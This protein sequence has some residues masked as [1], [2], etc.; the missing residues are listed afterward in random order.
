MSIV[1]HRDTFEYHAGEDILGKFRAEPNGPWVHDPD[2]TAVL[3]I[4]IDA[5]TDP[6]T[7]TVTERMPMKDWKWVDDA[8]VE[9]SQGEKD[10]VAATNLES[11]RALRVSAMN[12]R[13]LEILG[14]SIVTAGFFT[15]LT[16]LQA[17][18]AGALAHKAVLDAA[19]NQAELDTAIDT[20][21][22]ADPDP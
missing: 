15:D 12:S 7:Y 17:I 18:G 8:V 2:V 13:T 4:E 16:A 22:A 19:T 20:R 5:E 3:T 10:A 6:D 1:V 11:N 9:M 14:E 21:T